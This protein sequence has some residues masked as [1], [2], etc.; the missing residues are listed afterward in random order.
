MIRGGQKE[1]LSHLIIVC[2]AQCTG[3][4]P[5]LVKGCEIFLVPVVMDL[6]PFSENIAKMPIKALLLASSSHQNA[7]WQVS[8]LPSADFCV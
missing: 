8:I 7:E 6:M 1:L 2:S 3:I 5:T 4:C